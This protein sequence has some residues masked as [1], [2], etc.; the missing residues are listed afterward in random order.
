MVDDKPGAAGTTEGWAEDSKPAGAP[1]A[2][3]RRWITRRR[4]WLATILL[5]LLGF[6]AVSFLHHFTRPDAV[7]AMAAQWLEQATGLNVQIGEAQFSLGGPLR[8]HNVHFDLPEDRPDRRLLTVQ[9]VEIRFKLRSLARGQ[10]LVNRVAIHGPSAF[11][12]EDEATGI[13]NYYQWWKM[14]GDRPP[15]ERLAQLPE[16]SLSE[17]RVVFATLRDGRIF[18]SRTMRMSGRLQ[19]DAAEGPDWYRFWILPDSPSGADAQGSRL[20][21]APRAGPSVQGTLQLESGEISFAIH[22]VDLTS[23]IT[24]L[25]PRDIR[26][27]LSEHDFQGVIS[28]TTLSTAQDARLDARIDLSG[29]RFITPHAEAPLFASVKTG[30]LYIHRGPGDAARSGE[31]RPFDAEIDAE[32]DIADFKFT[33]KGTI[34]DVFAADT[35]PDLSF[36]LA[37][38]LTRDPEWVQWLKDDVRR[39]VERR[40][41]EFAPEGPITANLRV[42]RDDDPAS[43][44][45]IDYICTLTLERIQASHRAFRYPVSDLT[46]QVIIRPDTVDARNLK[47][48]GPTGQAIRITVSATKM[49]STPIT[50]VDISADKMPIERTHLRA[51][52]R[53]Q[54]WRIIESLID[55]DAFEHLTSL[56]LL[57]PGFRPGGAV[58]IE[59]TVIDDP[60]RSPRTT[61]D[62]RLDLT[63]FRFLP[64]VWPYPIIVEQ[65]QIRIVGQTVEVTDMKG[66]GIG[67]A[68]IEV[69]GQ[70]DLWP[71]PQQADLPGDLTDGDAPRSPPGLRVRASDVPVDERLLAT[72][73][74]EERQWV[75]DLNVSGRLSAVAMIHGRQADRP[76]Y[77]IAINVQGLAAHPV[78][79]A[80]DV[81]PMVFTDGRIEIEPTQLTLR[82]LEVDHAG[83]RWTLNGRRARQ[84]DGTWETDLTF[85]ATSLRLTDPLLVRISGSPGVGLDLATPL[86]RYKVRGTVDARLSV[87]LPGDG[88]AEISGSITPVEVAMVID[89]SPIAMSGRRG[90]VEF[91]RD[92][93]MF[94]KVELE[95]PEGSLTLDGHLTLTPAVDADL[96]LAFDGRL[97]SPA[98]NTIVGRNTRGFLDTPAIAGRISME[99]LS[100]R[101]RPVENARE[102][103]SEGAGEDAEPMIDV[104]GRIGLS[105]MDASVGLPISEFNGHADIT[106]RSRREAQPPYLELDLHAASM[107]WGDRR[108]Q[109]LSAKIQT[110]PDGYRLAGIQASLYDGSMTGHG[111]IVTRDD[112]PEFA[113]EVALQDVALM[114][115]L[116]PETEA[117]WREMKA[118]QDA[119]PGRRARTEDEPAT[120]TAQGI[121]SAGLTIRGTI[122][123]PDAYTGRGLIQV[124]DGRL[125]EF[126]LFTNVLR[127]LNFQLPAGSTFDQASAQFIVDGSRLVFEDIRFKADSLEMRGRGTMAFED[128][129]LDLLFHSR[130]PGNGDSPGPFAEIFRKLRS[131]IVSVEVT[132]PLPNPEARI[133]SL[134]ATRE[135]LQ[136]IF[137][138]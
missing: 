56:E 14:L 60:S 136:E 50:T 19:T 73:P 43:P 67:G 4:L 83:G 117:R 126:P 108:I 95:L 100:V 11:V 123:K 78:D 76:E 33:L 119:G 120:E 13:L 105:D 17:G 30:E 10:L 107:L 52:M 87:R 7:R 125:F 27:F 133:E 106:Y 37:G 62:I 18:S 109:P 47:G 113:L 132:G 122:G 6:A 42:F 137:G 74:K 98:L 72:L 115:F 44:R 124:R 111:R 39:Q 75:K 118:N 82:S 58:N 88:P 22:S 26:R 102:D 112:L 89:Q 80:P 77:H 94:N 24:T 96:K 61:S 20:V 25:L 41:Q 114:P 51:A 53:D 29:M 84:S 23:P 5:T 104:R 129:R 59:A 91:T 8:L 99:D 121:V 64:R 70:A 35:R 86:E 130:N 12:S 127:V 16:V 110:A 85:D 31:S 131:E 65:G 116:D 63:D 46:G 54:D 1:A 57:G 135:T 69:S 101:I 138:Q 15:A 90:Q 93:F 48:V 34:S 92:R 134:R 9:T 55:Q 66:H 81:E 36:V 97:P 45:P 128:R 32:G 68:A 3:S 49:R 21:D 71:T 79:D 38:N 40:I 103:T 2:R 28:K